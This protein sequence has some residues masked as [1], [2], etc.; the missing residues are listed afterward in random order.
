MAETAYIYVIGTPGVRAVKIGWAGDARA[1]L[2]ALQ[3]GSP[4]PLS[5]MWKRR[6]SDAAAVEAALHQLFG[7]KRVRGEWFDLGPDAVRVVRE[8]CA[9]I[10]EEFP[11]SAPTFADEEKVLSVLREAGKAVTAQMVTG[12]AGIPCT[13]VR[14]ILARLVKRGDARQLGAGRLLFEITETG[15]TR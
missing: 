13:D 12:L 7:G 3:T 6:M 10:A 15:V 1:R 9:D 8:A 14:V 11:R 5:V 4:L 2:A